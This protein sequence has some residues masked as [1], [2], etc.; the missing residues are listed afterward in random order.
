MHIYICPLVYFKILIS[1]RHGQMKLVT[2][3]SNSQCYTLAN[4][5]PIRCNVHLWIVFGS[6]T[7]GKIRCTGVLCALQVCKCN[8][9]PQPCDIDQAA[10]HYTLSASVHA[11]SLKN[12]IC[13][14]PLAC[15]PAR[16][17][18][19]GMESGTES[20]S[21]P[22]YLLCTGVVLLDCRLVATITSSAPGSSAT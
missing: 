12:Q 19:S 9:H 6:N 7:S 10:F 3:F 15:Q 5:K 2:N 18:L 1:T 8:Q 4:A 16:C 11:N 17:Y 13:T 21:E 22:S 20:L 14:P